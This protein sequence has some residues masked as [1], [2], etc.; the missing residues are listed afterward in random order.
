M[1][2]S[3]SLY[4]SAPISDL[5]PSGF[6]GLWGLPALIAG[7]PGSRLKILFS[8]EASKGSDM[9]L[10]SPGNNSVSDSEYDAVM[11]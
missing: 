9:M 11:V 6:R 1:F 8:G 10:P 7:D 5:E 2:D 3:I 4:K